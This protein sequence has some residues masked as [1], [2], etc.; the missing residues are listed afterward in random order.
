MVQ[1]A[2]EADNWPRDIQ[3]IPRMYHEGLL[4]VLAWKYILLPE[5]LQRE[6]SLVAFE[7]VIVAWDPGF[8]IIAWIG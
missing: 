2:T 7:N 1:P 6:K 5:L 4:S 3:T 8:G